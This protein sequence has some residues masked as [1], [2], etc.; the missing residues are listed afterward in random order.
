VAQAGRRE[1]RI[2]G[3]DEHRAVGDAPDQGPR[4]RQRERVGP[5][6]VESVTWACAGG[7]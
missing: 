6:G 1:A 3:G 7:P 4:G 5:D 2:A